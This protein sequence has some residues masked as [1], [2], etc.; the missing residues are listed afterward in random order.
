MKNQKLWKRLAIVSGAMFV[1]MTGLV[2]MADQAKPELSREW[3]AKYEAWNNEANER[4]KEAN[5]ARR[6]GH[7]LGLVNAQAKY[8]D[9]L[10]ILK[11]DRTTTEE[12]ADDENHD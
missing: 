10:E 3:K 1:V 7:L 4:M 5:S 12:G 9:H 2:R 6:R 8:M 11:A